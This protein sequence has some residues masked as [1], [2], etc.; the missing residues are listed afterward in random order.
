MAFFS[1]FF[2]GWGHWKTRITP[3]F[4]TLIPAG[5]AQ[6]HPQRMPKLL[7]RVPGAHCVPRGP[8][9]NHSG[10]VPARPGTAWAPRSCLIAARKNA[11]KPAGP[12]P[13]RAPLSAPRLLGSTWEGEGAGVGPRGS[14]PA[15]R[16][17]ATPALG[18]LCP[19][20]SAVPRRDARPRGCG[21]GGPAWV[22]SPLGAGPPAA[23]PR[24]AEP[25]RACS[26]PFYLMRSLPLMRLRRLRCPPSPAQPPPLPPH[27]N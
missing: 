24:R 16:H 25:F 1:F 2:P 6:A 11:G 14:L 19:A 27:S 20:R 18:P 13:S 9:K 3:R 7:R 23:A 15:P 21:R 22:C 8:G 26:L 17:V 5:Q 10:S 12:G 4:P